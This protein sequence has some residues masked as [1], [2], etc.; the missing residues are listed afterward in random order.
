MKRVSVLCTLLLWLAAPP[1]QAIEELEAE[2]S[3]AEL[4]PSAF[5][6]GD[7]SHDF[8]ERQ[9]AVLPE[10]GYGPDTGPLAGLK[11]AHRDLLRQRVNLDVEG[12]YSL[13]NHQGVNLSIGYPHL[14]NDRGLILLRAKYSLDPQRD[15]FGLGN[16]DIGPDPASTHEFQEIA[17]AL[18]LGYRLFE[19]LALNLGVGWRK[20]DIRDGDRL[21]DC[22]G[23]DPCPFT[24]ERFPDLPGVDGGVVNPLSFSLVWN[25][26]DDIMR[27]TRGFRVILKIV[28]ANHAF[29]DFKFVRYFVDVGY[30]RPFFDKRII[31]G[32]RLN[33]EYNGARSGQVP[34]WELA[35][36][37]GQDTLRGF[38]P[39][40]FAG[41]A[42]VLLNG[43]LR[44]KL[45]EFDFFRLWHVKFDAVAFG[46]G[47]RV[48]IDKEELEDEFHLDSD[49]FSRIFENFQYSYGGG[50][51][52]V[53]SE[54]LVARIDV[55]FSDEYTGLVY[56]SFGHT[57]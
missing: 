16:N 23:L 51:R 54:A 24:P 37:G 34:F 43:E 4:L 30:L 12:T 8:S 21:D 11:F 35:E 3:I 49:I 10:F 20:V 33:G 50:F 14:W 2:E 15:F 56:L 55:G 52:I 40:R 29:S 42:R 18:T 47:G 36:L 32:T 46:D 38:F 1:V 7:R 9:W 41:T 26:R 28:L 44:A 5:P 17:G 6:A 57:F 53:L 39:H 22:N 19:R 27:P 31:F 13:N 25:D 48:F 45:F